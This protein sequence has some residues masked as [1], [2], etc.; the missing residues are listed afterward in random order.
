MVAIAVGLDGVS[1]AL[2]GAIAGTAL[3]VLGLLVYSVMAM[4]ER[5]HAAS[6]D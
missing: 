4:R 5:G 1:G 2:V 3:T 6:L